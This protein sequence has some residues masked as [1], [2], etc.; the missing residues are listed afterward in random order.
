MVVFFSET[1]RHFYAGP[2]KADEIA[3]IAKNGS[4]DESVTV[5][6]KKILKYCHTSFSDTIVASHCFVLFYRNLYSRITKIGVL[7]KLQWKETQLS[8]A[9][10]MIGISVIRRFIV[11][12][13]TTWYAL[14]VKSQSQVSCLSCSVFKSTT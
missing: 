14:V 2:F 10:L 12:I 13:T 5:D 7:L 8:A 4:Q 3:V 11:T 9:V 1:T 6:Y